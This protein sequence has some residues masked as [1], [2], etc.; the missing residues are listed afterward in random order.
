MNF[1]PNKFKFKK[2]RKGKQFN[3]IY[4]N[5][6]YVQL[7]YGSIGLKCLEFGRITSKQIEATRSSISKIIKK[8]GKLFINIFPDTP[9]SKKPLEIRMGKGKGGVD[10]WIYKI[11]PGV[12]LCEIE[13]SLTAL[14]VK[15]LKRAQIRFPL[16]T[17]IIYS[18]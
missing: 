2:H 9:V 7:N 1:I 8:S 4:K 3:K 6:D 14:G 11:Q 10:R 5:V 16:K 15:A 17:K 18:F 13:T 12:V